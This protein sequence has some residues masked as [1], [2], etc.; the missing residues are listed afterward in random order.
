MK[1]HTNNPK[2]AFVFSGGASLGAVEC[3]ALK[4]IVEHG[5]QADM[6]LGTSVGSLNGAMYAFNPTI[7]G[8]K[9][10]EDVWHNIKVWN[11]FSPSP[12]TPILNITTFGLN[13]ISS[14]NIRKL[15]SD[16]LQFTRIEE[17]KLPLYIIGTDIKCGEE[18]VFNKG[19]A[20]EA[21]MSSVAIPGAFPPQRME[22]CSIVDG[23]IVNNAPISTAVR[24][25]AERVVVFPIGV[26]SAD[27]EPKTVAEVIIRSFIFLLNRQLASDIQLYK[28]KVE[29]III[30]PPDC[31]DVG[32]HDFSKSKQLIEESYAKAKEWLEN[33]G[34][35]P[36]AD[37]HIHPC[38]VH[39]PP[40]NLMEAVVPEPEM[41][42]TTRAKEGLKHS[43]RGIKKS[44][45][46]T[47]DEIYTDLVK[48]ADEIKKKL[49][50]KNTKDE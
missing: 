6:V 31:I 23:G 12:I 46:E 30:P 26:P 21:L 19:L 36:N 50:K 22:N 5:I 16:N 17:T 10:I 42:V 1:E 41:K 7:E 3:G 40:V 13:L 43:T 29:L 24:L 20:L 15:I 11:V 32:P 45:D 49:F 48:T 4:A 8:V 28:D 25:G 27:Q 44:L 33:E 39:T 35:S 2:T 47:V 38:D 9:A 37:T 14:K 34:F 18:V